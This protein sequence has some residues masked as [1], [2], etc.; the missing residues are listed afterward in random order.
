MI[1]F[2]E[3]VE[4]AR[5]FGGSYETPNELFDLVVHGI[6]KV[7]L[8]AGPGLISVRTH[9]RPNAFQGGPMLGYG[10]GC[11]QFVDGPLC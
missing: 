3:P 5:A 2:G 4:V 8:G 10:G 11:H 6:G 7:A 1:R 9:N